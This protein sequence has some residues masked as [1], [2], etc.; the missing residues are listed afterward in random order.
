VQNAL[1]AIAVG[2][3]LNIPFEKVKAGI[4]KFTGV[5]RRWK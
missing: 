4:E 3:E 5:F 1:A 2:L